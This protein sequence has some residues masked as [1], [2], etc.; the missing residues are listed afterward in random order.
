MICYH[1]TTHGRVK[2]IIRNGLLPNSKPTWFNSP[3]PYVMLSPKPWIGLN[4]GESVVIKVT[5]PAIKPEYFTPEGCRW[6]HKIKREYLS[7][8]PVIATPLDK[9][10]DHIR[11]LKPEDNGTG[12]MT[13]ADFERLL[14][15]A[16]AY[17]KDV[18]R[19]TKD[20]NAST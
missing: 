16:G 8:E 1:T 20:E 18:S 3:T 4:G 12:I 6:P 15:E 11:T 19:E 2:S 10:V 7:V 9:V 5:D 14:I 13:E 17:I